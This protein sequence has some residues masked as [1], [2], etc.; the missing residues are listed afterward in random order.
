VHAVEQRERHVDAARNSRG[1]DHLALLDHSLL[2]VAGAEPFELVSPCPVGGG[3]ES[4]EDPGSGQVERAG[5]H[6]CGPGG[7]GVHLAEPFNDSIV[8]VGEQLAG[9]DDDIGGGHIGERRR[10]HEGAA[11]RVVDH[12]SGL[13]GHEHHLVSGH[14]RQHLERPDDVEGGELG[15]EGELDLHRVRTSPCPQRES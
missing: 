10:R 7:A 6:A 5:A 13:A 2:G 8:S 11:P 12:R 9:D 15:I 4:L 3:V 14:V 1:G